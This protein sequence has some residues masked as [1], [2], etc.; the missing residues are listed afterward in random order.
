METKPDIIISKRNEVYAK[1]T[2]ERAI[3]QELSDRLTFMVPGYQY[4]P[5]YRNKIFDGKIRLLNTQTNLLYFGLI[6]H[7]EEFCASRGYTFEYDETRADLEDPFSL[8]TANDFFESLNLHAHGKPIK[9][10]D[11]QVVAFTHSMQ[12][13]RALLLSP[14]SSGK[15]LIIYLLFR[16]L[17][18]YQDL[19]GLIIV[20]TVNLVT[21]LYSDFEDYSSHNGFS[22]EDNVYKI[23]QGQS[24]NTDKKLV[25]STW[26]S[27]YKQDKDYLDQFDYVFCDEAHLAQAN[28]IRDIMEKLTETKYRIGLTGTLSGM[29][30]NQWVLEGLFGTVKKVITTKELIDDKKIADLNIK[31]LVL[32]HP[33]E[34][35]ELLKSC[36]YQEEIEYLI[37]NELRNNFIKNLAVSM[38]SNTLVLFQMVDKHGKILYN[39]IKNSKHIGDRKVFFVHGGT[40]SDDREYIRKIVE[41]ESNAIIVASFGVYSTGVSIRNL[42]NIIFASPSKSRVRNLQSIGRGLRHS[43]GKVA[44]TLYDIADDIRHKKHVNFTLKHFSDRV[45]IYTEEHFKY[46]LYKINLK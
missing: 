10:N 15:S 31:C 6:P 40:D 43:E 45:K 46:K 18:D 41:Q 35:C 37:S 8:K 22:V 17:L 21:Q 9:V 30:T 42:H 7:I 5:S 13:K 24:K 27:L 1:V 11:H 34:S 29:K 33:D 44:A 16:Q 2:C 3:A 23:Y 25:I 26:Q 14:T 38:K 4:M 28:S 32:K 12:K 19:K 20:P 39:L 36:T